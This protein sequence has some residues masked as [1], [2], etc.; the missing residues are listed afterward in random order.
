M[1]SMEIALVVNPASHGGRT[2]RRW[3]RIQPKIRAGLGFLPRVAFTRGP[4]DACRLV[5]KFI[6]QNAAMIVSVGGDGTHNEVL[7]GLVHNGQLL[8]PDACMAIIDMGTG[9]DL[10]RSLGWQRSLKLSLGRLSRPCFRSLDVGMGTF[11]GMD[12]RTIRRAFINVADFGAGGETVARVNRSRKRLG[13]KATYLGCILMTLMT[14]RNKRVSYR[15]D[16]GPVVTTKLLNFIVANGRYYGDGIEA[17]PRALMD[18]GRLDMVAIGDFRLAEAL[19]HLPRF[20]KGTHLNHP[21]IAW[22]QARTMEAW[23]DAPVRI[24]MDGECVGTLP[25]RFDLLAAKLRFAA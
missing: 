2:G 24:N 14:Y 21:K 18:D 25:V 4:G 15:I 5:R 10:T 8:N 19:V 13:S 6:D 23:S 17:A 22:K 11:R 1:P 3:K 7:N 9:G 12:G 20:L 16:N